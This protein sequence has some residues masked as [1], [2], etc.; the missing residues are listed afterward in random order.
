MLRPWD[1]K[2]L[3]SR[4]ILDS[5]IQRNLIG[6]QAGNG[7]DAG[8]NFASGAF[9]R[10]AQENAANGPRQLAFGPQLWN[11]N[12]FIAAD[13]GD[14]SSCLAFCCGRLLATNGQYLLSFTDRWQRSPDHRAYSGA[15]RRSPSKVT[16]SA[17]RLHGRKDNRLIGL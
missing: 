6:S 9:A 1:W 2:R 7:P 3:S 17:S 13:G 8:Q 11:A 12:R 4:P 10:F 5:L 15:E 14:K 16:A